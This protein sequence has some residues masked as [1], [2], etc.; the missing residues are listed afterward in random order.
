MGL[1][2]EQPCTGISMAAGHGSQGPYLSSP[3]QASVNAV[4]L[5]SKIPIK[6]V[7]FI[8][9]IIGKLPNW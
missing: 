8:F 6:H 9:L 5:I 1:E 4:M 3:A 2:C 7:A